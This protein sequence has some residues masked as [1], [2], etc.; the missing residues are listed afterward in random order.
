MNRTLLVVAAASVL[1]LLA[2]G[3]R[4]LRGW[5]RGTA[6]A[7]PP[8]YTASILLVKLAMGSSGRPDGH[9]LEELVYPRDRRDWDQPVAAPG[10]FAGALNF[11]LSTGDVIESDGRFLPSPA[12]QAVVDGLYPRVG[13]GEALERGVAAYL[14][15]RRRA[16]TAARFTPDDAEIRAAFAAHAARTGP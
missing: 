2:L 15:D 5:N 1:V 11:L 6:S 4:W 14:R 8:L 13:L 12:A 10:Q 9:T 7:P 3:W 16:R